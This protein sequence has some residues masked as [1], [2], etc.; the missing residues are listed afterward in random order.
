MARW[1]DR[2]AGEQPGLSEM[3]TLTRLGPDTPSI[4]E[5][6]NKELEDTLAIER[7]KVRPRPPLPSQPAA[8]RPRRARAAAQGQT[9]QTLPHVL[10]RHLAAVFWA[11]GGPGALWRGPRS[12]HLHGSSTCTFTA[13]APTLH[14]HCACTWP[15]AAATALPLA[16]HPW[17]VA[18]QGDPAGGPG[19]T[20][21]AGV[22]SQH[23]HTRRPGG[24]RADHLQLEAPSR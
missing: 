7:K 8:H 10:P 1:R 12:Q 2:L 24:G 15:A 14:L 5:K 9:G 4:M 6:G 21:R 11:Q 22:A 19:A 23:G 3:A 13:P 16:L 20:A 18:G 17:I